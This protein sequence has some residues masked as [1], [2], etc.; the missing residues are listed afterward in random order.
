MRF[1]RRQG[2]LPDGLDREALRE[3]MSTTP[4]SLAVVFGSFATE[5]T[6]PLSDLDVAVRFESDVPHSRKVELLGELA[7]ELGRATGIDAIDL[8]DLDTVGPALGYEALA[9]GV[10][11][12]GDADDA[13]E[14]QA[15]FLVRKLDLQPV[16]R[17]WDDALTDRVQEG[18]FGRP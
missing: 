18:Q 6:T 15:R 7:G 16:K 11:I 1:T 12:Y 8:V 9:D 13:A 17:R 10:L 4:V 5:T 14:L 3:A 2:S